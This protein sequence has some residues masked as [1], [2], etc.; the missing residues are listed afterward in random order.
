[1]KITGKIKVI[2]EDD[3]WEQSLSLKVYFKEEGQLFNKTWV[4]TVIGGG[5]RGNIAKNEF[6]DKCLNYL[7]N[8]DQ[9]REE[10]KDM[11]LTCYQEKEKSIKKLNRDKQVQEMIKNNKEIK[12]EMEIK[13]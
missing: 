12:F 6:I 11:V 5:F 10:A 13:K 1:M 4:R 9:I 8:E 2:H 3:D 7:S